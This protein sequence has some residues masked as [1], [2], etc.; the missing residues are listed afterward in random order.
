[1]LHGFLGVLCV[2]ARN[3]LFGII[4]FIPSQLQIFLDVECSVFEV[5][6]KSPNVASSRREAASAGREKDGLTQRRNA[7]TNV[8]MIK[9]Q[10]M[11]ISAPLSDSRM[12]LS[13]VNR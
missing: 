6:R 12:N 3:S 1:M 5:R 4:L 2:F 8:G 10:Q 7:A 13:T 9:R 11:R